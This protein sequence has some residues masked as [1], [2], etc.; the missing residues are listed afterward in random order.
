MEYR[1][2][3]YRSGCTI[4][5]Q[6]FY[7]VLLGIRANQHGWESRAIDNVFIERLWRSVKQ[8][9]IYYMLLKMD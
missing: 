2:L 9:S 8:E 7:I 3:Q 5:L 4:Y 1:D 6:R